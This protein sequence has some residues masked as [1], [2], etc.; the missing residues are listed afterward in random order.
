[1]NCEIHTALN[2]VMNLANLHVSC[3][4]PNC[5]FYELGLLHPS[6]DMGYKM[7]LKK[8]FEEID[9]EGYIHIS[10]KPGLGVDID[11][12]YIEDNTIK[13]IEDTD[14]LGVF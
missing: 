6:T 8:D 5:Q 13:K 3:A 7:G 10:G 2:S 9:K 14:I 4:I 1:M 12:D 11:Y